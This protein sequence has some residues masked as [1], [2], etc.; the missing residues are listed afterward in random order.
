MC[1]QHDRQQKTGP[2]DDKTGRPKINCYGVRYIFSPYGLKL[3]A[4]KYVYKW[5]IYIFLGTFI[6]FQFYRSHCILIYN[7]L[8]LF[9]VVCKCYRIILL[10]NHLENI[11]PMHKLQKYNHRT[12]YFRYQNIANITTATCLYCCVSRG[13][14]ITSVWWLDLPMTKTQSAHLKSL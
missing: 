2:S 11:D 9:R 1:M 3:L 12:K 10:T 7:E 13:F 6:S 14:I 8:S 5:S 4:C